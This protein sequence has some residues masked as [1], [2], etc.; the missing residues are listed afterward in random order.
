MHIQIKLDNIERSKVCKSKYQNCNSSLHSIAAKAMRI[1]YSHQINSNEISIF[2]GN[3]QYIDPSL[4]E[5][6]LRVITLII[7]IILRCNSEYRQV[8]HYHDSAVFT[9]FVFI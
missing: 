9:R 1:Q 2:I 4:I 7:D 8:G 6:I 5:Q 3:Q